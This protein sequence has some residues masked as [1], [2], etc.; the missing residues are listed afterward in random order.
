MK[1]TIAIVD[2]NPLFLSQMRMLLERAGVG[3]VRSYEDPQKALE[4]FR[5]SPPSVLL[6][7][8][9]MPG[10]DGLQFLEI[11]QREG[12]IDH[13]PVAIVTGADDLESLRLP[14]LKAGAT[15]I[16]GKPIRPSEF[17]LA[18]RNLTRLATVSV[19]KA[20]GSTDGFRP[21]VL[22]RTGGAVTPR[23]DLNAEDAAAVR[24]LAKVAAIRDDAT[25]QHTQRM[26]EYAGVV[27]HH[28]GMSL[29]QQRQ[30]AAAAPLH[31]IG[32][33]GVPDSI[34]QKP[35]PLTPEERVLMQRH[36]TLG[37]EMLS[38]ERSPLMQLGAE[39]ALSHHEHWDGRGYPFGLAR[40][41]IPLSARIVCIADAFD[42]LTTVHPHRQSSL[43]DRAV[44][45]IANER[46]THFDPDVVDAF[47]AGLDE[48]K[49]IKRH[50][51]GDETFRPKLAAP[52]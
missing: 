25:G 17:A 39:I 24:L 48:I 51:D 41:S 43:I 33:I 9:L 49:L 32:K 7:D 34:L 44:A 31:D 37:Y 5:H 21:L 29:D 47:M 28:Y 11:L 45:V 12:I 50:F 52:H 23:H 27:A 16:I 15:E 18:V 14:A 1:Q 36:T 40:K 20:S 6:V 19:G 8:Y 22:P 10:I 30:L 46:G 38:D 3:E 35:G 4:D 13:T 26:A 2:D 42:A